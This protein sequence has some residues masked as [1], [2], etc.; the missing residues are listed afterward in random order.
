MFLHYRSNKLNDHSIHPNWC[1]SFDH[2]PLTITIPITEENIITSKLSIPK[3]SEQETAF[4]KEVITNFKNLNTSNLTNK[5]KLKD[6]VKLLESLS[7][8][9]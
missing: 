8:Q 1:L 5:D 7:E 9:A 4:V 6:T 3:N 2:A